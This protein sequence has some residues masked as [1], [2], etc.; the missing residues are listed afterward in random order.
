[1]RKEY[2]KPFLVWWTGTWLMTG[3]GIYAG[4][5]LSG[6]DSVALISAVDA[7]LNTEL[8]S[9]V[10]PTAGNVAIAVALNEIIEPLRLPVAIATTP[11]VVSWIRS[12]R[13]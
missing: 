8:A 4:L 6:A 9:R 11:K 7:K 10:D 12:I 1:M 2:G 3:L 5:Q 13:K